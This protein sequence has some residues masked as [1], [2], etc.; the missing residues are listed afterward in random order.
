MPDFA[1]GHGSLLR[2]NDAQKG[3]KGTILFLKHKEQPSQ[4]Y[5]F[6]RA[7]Q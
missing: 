5:D 3:M 7:L 2:R 6:S 1:L 4:S